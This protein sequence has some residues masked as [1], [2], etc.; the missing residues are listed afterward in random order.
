MFPDAIG[1]RPLNAALAVQGEVTVLR[2]NEIVTTEVVAKEYR[3][4]EPLAREIVAEE[5]Q[6]ALRRSWVAWLVFLAGLGV[7]GYLYF[8]PGA[9][10]TTALWVLIGS[11]SAWMLVGRYL[12]GPAIRKAAQAKAARLHQLYS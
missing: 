4:N 1:P 6:R 3:L 12:A 10:K 5:T 9:D 11:I 2:E 7:S 8:A